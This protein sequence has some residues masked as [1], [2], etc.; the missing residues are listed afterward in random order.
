M[1]TAT[2]PSGVF[3]RQLQRATAQRGALDPVYQ[4]LSDHWTRMLQRMYPVWVMLGPHLSD[5]AHIELKSRTVYLDSL[6][7]LEA[8]RDDIIAGRLQLRPVLRTFGAAIHEVLHAKHTKTWV[9]EYDAELGD[10]Q[11]A[12]DRRLL[13]EPRMEAT[14]CREYPGHTPRGRFIRSALQ[15]AV[16]DVIV[17]AFAD[18]VST[19]AV[20]GQPVTRDMAGRAMTYLQA[21]THYGVIDASHLQVLEPIWREVLGDSDMQ[22]LDDLYAQ[23][24]WVPDGDNDA[25]SDFAGRYRNIIGPPDP[26]QQAAGASGW[27]AGSS[28]DAAEDP[29]DSD[30]SDGPGQSPSQG[31]EGSSQPTKGPADGA[32]EGA[33]AG[34]GAES[35][36]GEGTAS[37]QSLADALQDAFDSARDAQ[38][39][40]FDEDVD[41]KE[42]LAA[43]AATGQ[44]APN[45]GGRGTGAPTGRMPDRGVNRRPMADEV[46][47]ARKFSTLLRRALTRITR[48]IDKMTPGGRFNGRSYARAVAE[49]TTGRRVTS[50]PWEIQQDVTAPIEEPHVGLIIDTSGS[51]HSY[52]YALGPIA[53]VLT[54]A[55]RAVD[56]RLAISLFGNGCELLTDGSKP[57]KQV[58]GIRTG[59]GTAFAG[60]AVELVCEHLEMT[61][62]KR[63]RLLFV[64]SDGGWYDTQA[65]VEKIRWLAEHHVPTIHIAIGMAP[66]AVECDRISVIT[67][68]ADAMT[69]VAEDT[70]AALQAANTPRRG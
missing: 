37:A 61:N 41:L 2:A 52:E 12:A 22:A 42:V 11:L 38:L 57:L 67:D 39:Q 17:K 65:G 33:G 68:P 46:Q 54:E 45:T 10:E 53:W 26:P 64:V 36:G 32:G 6:A 28:S 15:A 40:Q 18:Q 7:L 20:T 35:D 69:I 21:R 13:E 49:R 4:E 50:R 48:R 62:E 24:I 8:D 44:A 14:G 29:G 25:L 31:G 51:M 60:D 59:G 1:A 43:A 47:Q 66:L 58:P 70:L 34:A 63:P 16:V 3:S 30:D 5:P 55:L 27:G 56:G 9:G 19:A 23:L